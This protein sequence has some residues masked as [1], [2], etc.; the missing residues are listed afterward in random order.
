MAP[1]FLCWPTAQQS[2]QDNHENN[3]AL[4]FRFLVLIIS[5]YLRVKSLIVRTNV[6]QFV[7]ITKTIRVDPET[8]KF[9]LWPT[10]NEDSKGIAASWLYSA[11][12][13]M[14]H[15]R[16]LE[17]LPTQAQWH[18]VSNT[19]EKATR[20]RVC[21]TLFLR[22]SASRK[23]VSRRLKKATTSVAKLYGYSCCLCYCCCC[24]F[25]SSVGF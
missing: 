25:C 24:Y 13:V 8:D 3:N 10:K 17:L 19:I 1:I 2:N 21:K 11:T 15:V 23:V 9:F 7:G 16:S 12:A 6:P 5:A 22:Q 18:Q 14:W 4:E 20:V